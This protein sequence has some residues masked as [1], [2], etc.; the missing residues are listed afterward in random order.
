MQLPSRKPVRRDDGADGPSGSRQ[1]AQRG[2]SRR[3]KHCAT[4]YIHP[5]W[6]LPQPCISTPHSCP[7]AWPVLH[8]LHARSSS[9]SMRVCPYN[10]HTCLC[11]ARV[12]LQYLYMPVCYALVLFPNVWKVVIDIRTVA[13]SLPTSI[14]AMFYQ[15]TSSDVEIAQIRTA[16]EVYLASRPSCA[17]A[18]PIRQYRPP[19]HLTRTSLRAR[20]SS[21]KS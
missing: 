10:T 7:R 18:S 13:G 1:D 8:P 20:S 17:L 9:P 6:P 3:S 16:H 11:Y 14:E 12:P 21:C 19:M 4:S 2:E 15:T 5:I